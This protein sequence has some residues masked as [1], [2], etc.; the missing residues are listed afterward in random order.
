MARRVKQT[1]SLLMAAVLMVTMAPWLQGQ[2]QAAPGDP[3]AYVQFDDFSTDVNFPT[4]VNTS[5]INLKGSFTAV[6]SDSLSFK[7]ERLEN[8][9]VVES[10]TGSSTPQISGSNF[11]FAGISLFNGLNRVSV[12]ARNDSG[13]T[14]E[15]PVYVYFG[16]APYIS[17]VTLAD[18]RPLSD[19]TPVLVNIENPS[20]IIKATNTTTVTVNGVTS[21]NGGAGTFVLSDLNLDSGLNNLA[22][23]A[24][25]EDRTYGLDRKLVY[26]NGD[27]T[28]YNVTLG[29]TLLDGN[30]T[31]APVT[32]ASSTIS[33][34][35]VFL[36]PDTT[37]AAPAIT[38]E[39]KDTLG[40][41]VVAPTA[42]PITDTSTSSEWVTFDFET[43]AGT[44]V[45]SNGNYVLVVTSTAYNG[46]TAN[47]AVPFSVRD[48][49]SPYITGTRQLYSVTDPASVGG[50]V[51]YG[52]VTQFS[53]NTTIYELPLYL[54][55]ETENADLADDT[56]T[57]TASNGGLTKADFTGN[58]GAYR[59]FKITALPEGE[60][61][62]DFTV[63]EGGGTGNT[64][65]VSRTVQFIPIP[66]IQPMNVYNGQQFNVA[67]DLTAFNLKLNNFSAAEA[68]NVRVT[69]NGVTKTVGNATP[70]GGVY[71]IP[72]GT[73]LKLVPGTN[74]IVFSG[75]A[76]GVP[77]TTKVV[78]YLFSAD[79]PFVSGVVPVPYIVNP[80]EWTSTDPQG[81]YVLTGTDEY[82][83]H[84]SRVDILFKVKN[85][86]DLIIR[87]DGV[88]YA[89]AAVDSGDNSLDVD[90]ANV[91]QLIV[92]TSNTS[93]REYGLRLHGLQ[94]PQSGTISITIVT[95]NQA[96]NASQTITIIRELS[97]YIVLSPLLPNESVVNQ[98]FLNVVI[99]AEG[100]DSVLLGKETMVKG[101]NDIFRLEYNGLRRGK[102]KIGFTVL[103]GTEELE[104][105]FEVTYAESPTVGAQYKTAISRSG[106]ISAFDKSIEIALPRNTYLTPASMTQAE[107]VGLVADQ[108]VLVGIA[109][110]YD[111]RT[112]KREN[113]DGTINIVSSAPGFLYPRSHF[114]FASDLFWVDSGS[115]DDAD[116]YTFNP[117]AHPYQS[118][119]QFYARNEQ[120]W[121][122]PTQRGEITLTYDGNLTNV[123]ANNLGIWR[124]NNFTRGWE[125]IGGIVN[126]RRKTITA[127]FDGFGYYAVM[128]LRY[129][130]GDIISHEY[131]RQSLERMLARGVMLPRD[132]NDFGVYENITRGEFAQI[133][134]KMTDIPLDYLGELTFQDVQAFA[135]PGA[136]WDYRYVETAARKGIVRGKGPRVF[137]PNDPLTREEAAVMIAR[138]TNL[139][140]GDED[141]EKDRIDLQKEFTDANLVTY[142]AVSAVLAVFD[143]EF[144]LG[145]PNTSAPGTFRFDPMA[146]LKRADTAIIAERVMRELKLL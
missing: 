131:A 54:M 121:L 12:I 90:N 105:E 79:E 118:G 50:E 35:L 51:T 128:G 8:G 24:S 19:Q 139:L 133:L 11:I 78:V 1:F 134:V 63:T 64:H 138:A 136:L 68:A 43:A 4:P 89:H 141:P 98:N 30:P 48:A 33:G 26:F 76:N 45:P 70:T 2:A 97:P 46:S 123:A 57:L 65:T 96:V 137:M 81:K 144:I 91:D 83:T 14:I 29:T 53:D 132:T 38:V 110:T 32:D 25:N 95:A 87:V 22:I 17:E 61:R 117:A 93:N 120:E 75:T 112:I 41:S 140:K 122:K 42:A 34:S 40:A 124:Y 52:S 135:I 142:Y 72:F 104:G 116:D 18:G 84:E 129:S 62:L 49:N 86:D 143:E 69:M 102:N 114:G 73:D 20:I 100:A 127:S 80:A 103:R 111:G 55:V 77:V 126:T 37:T 60:S 67:G 58:S 109:D 9:A 56:V 13:N 21:Y 92:E 74:E 101:S 85:L 71:T 28:A 47:Y 108:Q 16:N 107:E 119:N 6:S 31:I 66:N 7:V 88:Q 113:I 82:T 106:K 3:S 44:T 10:S 94:L 146:N 23:V 59:V 130:Y 15:A 145:L 5:V 125:N 27:P 99:Q 36:K 39:I 115:V